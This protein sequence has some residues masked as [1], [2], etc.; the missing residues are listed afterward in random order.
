M[1][2]GRKHL[3]AV[4]TTAIT[5]LASSEALAAGGGGY[6]PC[7]VPPA[8]VQP[9]IAPALFNRAEIIPPTMVKGEAVK[10]AVIV[11]DFEQPALIVPVIIQPRYDG[12]AEQLQRRQAESSAVQSVREGNVLLA[13]KPTA[14]SR[15]MKGVEACCGTAVGR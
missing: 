13:P 14:A 15:I 10:W 12:C 5:V 3:L 9:Y 4:V 2:V 6:K 11:P 7:M 8:Y 1:L